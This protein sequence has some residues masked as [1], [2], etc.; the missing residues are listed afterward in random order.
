MAEPALHVRVEQ[1]ADVTVV[2]FLTGRIREEHSDQFDEQV[3]RAS[4]RFPSPKVL[5]DF[6][7]VRFLSSSILGKLVKLNARLAARGGELRL[8][9]LDKRIAEVFK[10]T[11][12]DR[13]FSIHPSRDKAL[14]AFQ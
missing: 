7:G 9:S 2:T 5:L 13:I 11:N 4:E 1:D 14:R 6:S 3:V 10:L 8:A 12:L